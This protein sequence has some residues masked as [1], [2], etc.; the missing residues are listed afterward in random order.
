MRKLL[1]LLFVTLLA[2]QS[3]YAAAARYCEHEA[4]AAASH[5]GHHGHDHASAANDE[6]SSP[7]NVHLDCG[8]CQLGFAQSLA[9]HGVALDLQASHTV[10]ADD[11][12]RII[13]A[14]RD[15]FLRPPRPTAL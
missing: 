12:P 11:P 14:D 9:A 1:I 5:V 15:E 2:A 10:A 8:F 6:K 13:S 3:V 4:D 7:S